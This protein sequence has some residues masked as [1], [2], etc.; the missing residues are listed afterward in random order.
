M[1]L[2]D[3]IIKKFVDD[4][5][6]QSTT[7]RTQKK[8]SPKGK[9]K[10]GYTA[11]TADGTIVI[12]YLNYAGDLKQF[13]CDPKSIRRK[14]NHFSVRVAPTFKRI[15][16]NR[17]K[18]RILK[19]WR[20]PRSYPRNRCR[21]KPLLRIHPSST[22]PTGRGS[23]RNSKSSPAWWMT[24][25]TLSGCVS[26]RPFSTS[27]SNAPVL[28]IPKRSLKKLRGRNQPPRTSPNP[29]PRNRHR[30]LPDR[31][32]SSSPAAASAPMM[33]LKSFRKSG[34]NWGYSIP[35]N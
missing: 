24:R 1:G 21:F 31:S 11:P 16:L 20:L 3:D 6:D 14:G 25:A 29:S 2:F 17:S 34:R 12:E 7:T 28:A 26:R 35:I 18:T 27:R 5:S 30:I 4:G 33:P 9:R 19:A 13:I 32:L 15:S 8:K 23:K 10:K 22:T